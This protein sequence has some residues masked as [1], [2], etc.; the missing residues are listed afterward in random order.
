[1]YEAL[2]VFY[3]NFFAASLFRCGFPSD[4]DIREFP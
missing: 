3:A 1:M 2:V 4:G